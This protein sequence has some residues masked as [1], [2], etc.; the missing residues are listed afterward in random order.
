MQFFKSLSPKTVGVS[1]AVIT[2]AIWT[3]FIIIGR[4]SASHTLT[5]F[6]ISFLR[7][8]GAALVLFPLGWWM[9]RGGKLKGWLGLSPLAF[10]ATARIGLVGGLGFGILIYTGF[11]FAPAAHG[12]VLTPGSLPLWTTLFSVWLLGERVTAARAFSLA[13]IM[14]GGLLVGGSSLMLAF[15]G[16]DVWK[17]DLL[18]IGASMC[19][20]LYSVLVRRERLDA[21]KATIAIVVFAFFVYVPAYAVLALTG[22]VHSRL[23]TA[24]ASEIVFQM[25]FQ[26]VGSVA[27]SGITFNKMV[28]YFGPVRTTM[29]TALVPGGSALGAVYFLGEPLSWNLWTGLALVTAGIVFGLRA[30]RRDAVNRVAVEPRLTP[31]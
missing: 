11:F 17:G 13:L 23:A 3:S 27:I 25:L 6:D 5:P 15:S 12:S 14:G 9:G 22:L 21:V 19:W 18:F 1:A 31:R 29:F 2:V 20:S 10:R 30:L 16:G 26:G 8:I 24:P 4:A 7:F 28:E